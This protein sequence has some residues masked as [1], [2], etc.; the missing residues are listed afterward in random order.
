[1]SMDMHEHNSFKHDVDENQVRPTW[2]Q[3]SIKL[4]YIED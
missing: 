2:R 1:M 3:P 4:S